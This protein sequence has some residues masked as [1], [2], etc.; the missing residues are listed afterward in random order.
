[1]GSGGATCPG[2]G[3]FLSKWSKLALLAQG[4]R[5]SVDSQAPACRLNQR[6]P[7]CYAS[8]WHAESTSS[9]R[10][11]H[12]GLQGP[13]TNPWPSSSETC[14]KLEQMLV[15]VFFFFFIFFLKK[16]FFFSF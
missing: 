5:L 16:I 2:R 7:S 12:S 15:L 9:P 8:R 3:S 1:M 10:I 11:L 4:P 13:P 6:I 14:L